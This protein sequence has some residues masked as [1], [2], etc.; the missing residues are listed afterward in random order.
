MSG[1][2]GSSTKRILLCAAGVPA[3]VALQ[4]NN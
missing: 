4:G 2:E 3:S 1:P